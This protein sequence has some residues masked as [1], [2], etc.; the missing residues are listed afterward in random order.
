MHLHGGVCG[1]GSGQDIGKNLVVMV[2]MP[3]SQPGAQPPIFAWRGVDPDKGATGIMS[4][5]GRLG[6]RLL[7]RQ[8]RSHPLH[9]ALTRLFG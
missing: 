5:F 1:A 8:W 9:R 3:R 4:W 6:M 7:G 2:A